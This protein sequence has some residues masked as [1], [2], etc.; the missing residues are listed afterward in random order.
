MTRELPNGVLVG[1][2][3]IA[4]TLFALAAVLLVGTPGS[5]PGSP[6][7]PSSSGEVQIELPAAV[8]GLLFLSPLIVGVG[9]LIYRRLTEPGVR[10]MGGV[11]IGVLVLLLL[12]VL[13]MHGS[14][15][16]GSV[17]IG[18]PP[19][20]PPDN[21]TTGG[22]GSSGGGGGG[23][24]GSATFQL[25]IPPYVP[26]LVAGG[27]CVVVVVLALPGVVSRLADRARRSGGGAAPP[28]DRSEVA[29]ALSDA[30]AALERGADPRET[31]VRLYVR[32][33]ALVAPS[34]GELAAETPEEIRRLHLTAM[35]VPPDAATTLTRAFEEARYSTHP[36]ETGRL[37]HAQ[38][39]L[40]SA[41]A[42]LR[43][44]AAA[45]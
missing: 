15:G 22:G 38:S 9:A 37:A 1:A 5:A 14:G 13:L 39:A 28:A 35:G 34:A 10:S 11:V 43:R 33:L 7:R 2:V 25:S 20:P 29:A 16:S 8:W 42:A 4:A 31:I 23:G 3:L 6:G 18:T 44:G 26:W 17:S 24:F 27:L 45:G 40:R 12:Y 30:S 41:E 36:I 19:P 32:L 21:N